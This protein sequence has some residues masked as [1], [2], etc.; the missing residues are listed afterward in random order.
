[1]NKADLVAAV[2]ETAG[3]SR[4]DAE[5]A[6]AAFQYE[7]IKAI[8]EGDDIRLT[9]FGTFS[10]VT[11]EAH[12][13]RNP[14]TGEAIPVAI[15]GCGSRRRDPRLGKRTPGQVVRVGGFPPAN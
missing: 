9:G 6:I 11:R 1:V 4:K 15:Q 13:A 10:Q 3:L 8:T 7:V 14:R 2:A 5:S 12:T